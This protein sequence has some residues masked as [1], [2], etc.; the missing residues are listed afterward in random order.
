MKFEIKDMF[1]FMFQ[2]TLTM[3]RY[4]FCWTRSFEIKTKHLLSYKVAFYKRPTFGSN[5]KHQC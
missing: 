1:Y 5:N 3:M 2:K 4:S